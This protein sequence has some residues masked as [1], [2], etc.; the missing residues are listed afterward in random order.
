MV[1]HQV[2]RPH[3]CP[4]C[5]A[6]FQRPS[7][8][9]NHMKIHTYFPGRAM[10]SLSTSIPSPAPNYF[11]PST[12]AQPHQP[13]SNKVSVVSVPSYNGWD[14]TYTCEPDSG[15]AADG[16][17]LAQNQDLETSAASSNHELNYQSVETTQVMGI[18]E[19]IS[20]FDYE[21]NSGPVITDV[22]SFTVVAQNENNNQSGSEINNL[23]NVTQVDYMTKNPNL[24]FNSEGYGETAVKVESMPYASAVECSST[25]DTYTCPPV[26]QQPKPP[27][28]TSRRPHVCRHCGLGFTREKALESHAR[29]HQDHWGSPVE[30]DRCEETFPEHISLHQHQETCLGKVAETSLQQQQAQTE[31]FET[32]PCSVNPS[33]NTAQPAKLGKH[34][35]MECEKRFTTKQKLFR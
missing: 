13:I 11:P 24:N 1:C 6:D 34:A 3:R 22:S 14:V 4:H 16:D 18:S 31:R 10:V 17:V 26:T 12:S 7:S 35:C 19:N 23:G 33:S 2:E 21:G 15:S 27:A 28:D 20:Q 8:L 9:T 30:C 32:S 25:K 5:G 29:L